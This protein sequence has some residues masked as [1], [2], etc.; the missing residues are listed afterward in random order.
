MTHLDKI[1]IR[2]F[3]SIKTLENFELGDLNVLVGANGAGK[4]N[5]IELFR[6]ISAMMCSGAL[7]N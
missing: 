3:K 1:T 7:R 6:I 4:S 5:F 2:G